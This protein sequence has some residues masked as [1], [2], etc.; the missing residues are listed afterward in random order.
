[1]ERPYEGPKFTRAKGNRETGGGEG[2]YCRV[3]HST[4]IFMMRQSLSSQ[5][6]RLKLPFAEHLSLLVRDWR[7]RLLRFEDHGLKDGP[8][9]SV[10]KGFIGIYENNQ[11]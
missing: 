2:F 9:R 5:F 8:V 6:E 3:S 11:V 7:R 4:T 1:M 10:S